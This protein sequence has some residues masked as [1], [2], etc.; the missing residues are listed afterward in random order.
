MI[1][2]TNTPDFDEIRSIS[3][4]VEPST[5]SLKN[6]EEPSSN[7][8]SKNEDNEANKKVDDINLKNKCFHGIFKKIICEKNDIQKSEPKNKTLENN[9]KKNICDQIR[10]ILNKKPDTNSKQAS[11]NY[12]VCVA[13]RRCFKEI[14]KREQKKKENGVKITQDQNMIDNTVDNKPVDNSLNEDDTINDENNDHDKIEEVFLS[15]NFPLNI[16]KIFSFCFLF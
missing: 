3:I 10:K 13:F 2:I 14:N 5:S 9:Q 12:C 11:T 16:L 7:L 4:D 6:K 15:S 1:P 8:H